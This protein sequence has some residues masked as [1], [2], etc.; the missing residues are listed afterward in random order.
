MGC[1][2]CNVCHSTLSY[3]L[4]ACRK[5]VVPHDKML[6]EPGLQCIRVLMVQRLDTM[7]IRFSMVN[8]FLVVTSFWGSIS[9]H[10]NTIRLICTMT[11]EWPTMILGTYSTTPQ[12]T[13]LVWTSERYRL[14]TNITSPRYMVTLDWWGWNPGVCAVQM[15]NSGKSLHWQT[16]AGT[17]QLVQAKV[18]IWWEVGTWALRRVEWEELASSLHYKWANIFVAVSWNIQNTPDREVQWWLVAAY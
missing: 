5:C 17:D 7:Q 4:G 8:L 10:S 16:Q 18:W 15:L 11:R 1:I 12:I 2:Y 13:F 14:F 6:N 9:R 3:D